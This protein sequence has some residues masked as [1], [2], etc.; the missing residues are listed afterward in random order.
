MKNFLR[1]FLLTLLIL[2]SNVF[3]QAEDEEPFYLKEALARLKKKEPPLSVEARLNENEI[4]FRYKSFFVDYNRVDTQ[5]NLDY[6]KLKVNNEIFSLMGTG[7]EWS[8]GVTGI[9]WKD[10]DEKNFVPVPT[11]GIDFYIKVM[12]KMKIY[13]QFSGMPFGGFGRIYDAESGLRYS[14]SKHF[15]ITGGYRHLSTKVKH[16]KSYGGFKNSGFFIGVRSDF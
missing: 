3:A 5:N 11:L 13:A 9:C 12:P 7:I 2:P 8:Y 16:N 15:T 4:I 14:P 10:F 1:I 6:I